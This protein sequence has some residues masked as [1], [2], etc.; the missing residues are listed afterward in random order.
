MTISR[1]SR[2]S[3][4]AVALGTALVL[5]LARTAPAND[6]RAPGGTLDAVGPDGTPRGA[7]PLERTDVRVE[8]LEK[9]PF[10]GPLVV[11]VDGQAR[12]LGD[13]VARQIHV[14]KDERREQSA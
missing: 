14:K 4:G 8:V 11:R 5:L 3:L 1:R 7:C 10:D 13:K 2:S 6:A 12:T 9:H